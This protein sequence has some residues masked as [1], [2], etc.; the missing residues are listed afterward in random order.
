M[1]LDSNSLKTSEKCLNSNYI[2]MMKRVNFYFLLASLLLLAPSALSQQ[3]TCTADSIKSW[4]AF[5]ASD[6]MKGRT[7]GS[8]EIEKV[9]EWLSVKYKQ[10]G[11]Q[12][13]GKMNDFSQSYILNNDSSFVHKNIVGYIPSINKSDN[14]SHVI[15]LSA[16]F[17]HIGMRFSPV[18]GDSIFNGADD[19]ASGIVA[20]LAIAKTLFEQKLQPDSPIVFAAF[21]NEERGRLGSRYFCNSNVIPIQKIKINI[22]F[23]MLGR[24]DEFGKNKY[25]ITGHEYSNF[26]D[27]VVDFNKDRDWEIVDVGGIVNMLFRMSDNY[28]FVECAT[29]SNYCVPAHTIATSV[30][31]GRHVHQLHDEVEYIDF[32]NLSNAVI[33]LTQ[34]ILYVAGKNI[35]VKCN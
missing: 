2:M 12:H 21:S 1:F 20:M 14:D 7:N 9:A 5:L 30:G 34:L 18:N 28:S 8:Q 29:R 19:N 23:E 25:Y 11:L 16:H 27:I 35:L 32:D 10:Y 13:F 17:D 31:M 4:L 3:S 24:S 33:N 15:V 22:N 6:E 26:Q